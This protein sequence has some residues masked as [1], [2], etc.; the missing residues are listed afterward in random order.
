MHVFIVFHNLNASFLVFSYFSSVTS[1]FSS[2][3]VLST[4]SLTVASTSSFVALEV[5]RLVRIPRIKAHATD[6]IVTEP[7]LST[8]PPTPAIRI[9]ETVKRFAFWERSTFWIIFK[10]ETAIN[11]YNATQTPPIT[12]GGMVA[13]NVT[14]GAT[15]ADTIQR[16]AAVIIVTMEAF[17][18]IATQPTD[19]P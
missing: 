17:L 7:I 1:D 15:N 11:P 12:Q 16:I 2:V 18:V 9:T 8:I 5:K 4:A 19:S 10:P 13:R 6:V 14:N 3:S